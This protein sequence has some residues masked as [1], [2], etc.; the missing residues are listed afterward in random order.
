MVFDTATGA[1][2]TL[3]LPGDPVL[4]QPNVWL[5]DTTL[6]VTS[7]DVDPDQVQPEPHGVTFYRCT[8]PAGTCDMV[9]DVGPPPPEFGAVPGGRWNGP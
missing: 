4:A 5:D 2:I 9:A 3:D 6:Q 7:F 1:Q 8:L